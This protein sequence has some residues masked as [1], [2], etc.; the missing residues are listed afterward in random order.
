VVVVGFARAG[1]GDPRGRVDPYELRVDLPDGAV[2]DLPQ[3]EVLMNILDRAHP[4]GVTVDTRS[5]RARHVDM[6]GDGVATPLSAAFS[7]TFRP[8]QQRRHV[9]ERGVTLAE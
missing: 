6:D 2:V 7:R 4:I 9:G 1:R 5:L 3:Y 8:F